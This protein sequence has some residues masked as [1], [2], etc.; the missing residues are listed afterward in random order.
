MSRV[1]KE[2]YSPR[3]RTV[4]RPSNHSFSFIALEEELKHLE[5]SRSCLVLGIDRTSTNGAA[6]TPNSKIDSVGNS[7]AAPAIMR[8]YVEFV[9]NN[10]SLMVLRVL[11][12]PTY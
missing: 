7:L 2:L 6:N 3:P 10:Y 1:Q 5:D 4:C 11:D 9:I 8:C 12:Y